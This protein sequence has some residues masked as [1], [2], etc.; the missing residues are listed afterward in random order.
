MRDCLGMEMP[1]KLVEKNTSLL[2]KGPQ[3]LAEGPGNDYRKPMQE[4]KI[5]ICECFPKMARPFPVPLKRD[6]SKF[7]SSSS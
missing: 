5:L 4:L 7:Y 6:V 1:Y 3:T 2:I